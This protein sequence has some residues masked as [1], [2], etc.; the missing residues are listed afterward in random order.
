MN[1]PTDFNGVSSPALLDRSRGERNFLPVSLL[2]LDQPQT[3]AGILAKS[4][5]YVLGAFDHFLSLK[6]NRLNRSL[7]NTHSTLL[8][9]GKS[10]GGMSARMR[11]GVVRTWLP[12]FFR[13][14]FIFF[15]VEF[16]KQSRRSLTKTF[17]FFAMRGFL[18][19]SL[20]V[21]NVIYGDV[22]FL[23]ESLCKQLNTRVRQDVGKISQEN[24]NSN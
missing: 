12:S 14:D 7:G 21:H 15:A 16:V 5:I 11:G 18:A 2:P 1:S 22:P 19:E 13:V 20:D 3:G 6:D 17:R 24:G 23:P 4:S 10:A 8:Q 9:T